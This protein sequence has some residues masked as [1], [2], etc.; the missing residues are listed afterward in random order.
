M[1]KNFDA[2][3]PAIVDADRQFTIHGQTF[4]I[5][6]R[7]RPEVLAQLDALTESDSIHQT[8]GILDSVIDQIIRP[9]DRDRWKAARASDDDATLIDI[10]DMKEIANWAIGALVTRPLDT[11]A[12]SMPTPVSIAPS[13]TA[14]GFSPVA[15]PSTS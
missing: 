11:S 12:S 8:F 9:E 4:Q 5:R 6:N 3:T 14:P 13:S 7:V 1:T 2:D 10:P 15:V